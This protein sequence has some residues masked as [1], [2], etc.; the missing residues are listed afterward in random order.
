MAGG[1]KALRSGRS[2]PWR[3]GFGSPPLTR[4]PFGPPTNARLPGLPQHTRAPPLAAFLARPG[5]ALCALA[6]APGSRPLHARLSTP[7][8]S[9][10]AAARAWRASP[11]R[12]P[13]AS[14][15]WQPTLAGHSARA[16]ALPLTHPPPTGPRAGTGLR[17]PSF[18]LAP[19]PSA[20]AAMGGVRAPSPSHSA[21][22]H[23]R[24]P[25]PHP[26]PPTPPHPTDPRE[27]KRL[28]GSPSDFCLAH[29]AS[30]GAP[31]LRN[32]RHTVQHAV[33][34][35]PRP[36]GPPILSTPCS[37]RRPHRYIWVACGAPPRLSRGLARAHMPASRAPRSPAF[38]SPAHHSALPARALPRHAG[39]NPAAGSRRTVTEPSDPSPTRRRAHGRRP[40][41][42]CRAGASEPKPTTTRR[43]ASSAGGPPAGSHSAKRHCSS[44]TALLPRHQRGAGTLA[45][46]PSARAQAPGSGPSGLL[47]LS[48]AQRGDRAALPSLRLHG[49]C[50]AATPAQPSPAQPC[51]AL[52]C[53]ALPCPFTL[54][55]SGEPRRWRP[56]PAT[57]RLAAGSPP[58]RGLGRAHVGSSGAVAR[59]RSPPLDGARRGPGQARGSSGRRGR[60]AAA[61]G[62]TQGGMGRGPPRSV[63]APPPRRTG[64]RAP[65]GLPVAPPPTAA[66]GALQRPR[67]LSSSCPVRQPTGSDGGD[68]PAIPGVGYAAVALPAGDV[69]LSRSDPRLLPEGP[70]SHPPPPCRPRGLAAPGPCLAARSRK[71]RTSL[72]AR[73]AHL[74]HPGLPPH[75]THRGSPPGPPSS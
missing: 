70:Q 60:V 39:P 44:K 8:A 1:P 36:P 67:S 32:G 48:A 61:L 74:A 5:L 68:G 69:P 46:E 50:T 2:P 73:G 41:P 38:C 13:S 35:R 58:P 26:T 62:R 17:A 52:P 31:R 23:S 4:R 9:P 24:L 11:G 15:H 42:V 45:G 7:P 34:S 37:G 33:L 71:P 55:S 49:L 72:R 53:P 12:L 30:L 21:P 66:P 6:A 27:Q 51:P 65:P 3:R 28:H 56:A 25:L 16:P 22:T 59:H 20:R 47:A 63:A 18:R 54:L 10:P 29:S 14:G 64:A 57:R 19:L 40:S 75:A 43:R